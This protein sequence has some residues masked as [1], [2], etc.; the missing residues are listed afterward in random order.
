L[1]TELHQNGIRCG[2]A[3]FGETIFSLVTPTQEKTLFEILK[4][5]EKCIVIQ[6]EIDNTGARLQ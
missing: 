5:Y 3:L 2:V 1:S 6:S 4:K